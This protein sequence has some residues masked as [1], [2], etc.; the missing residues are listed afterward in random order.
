MKVILGDFWEGSFLLQYSNC[1]ALLAVY[2]PGLVLLLSQL[3]FTGKASIPGAKLSDH[4]EL[5]GFAR[6]HDLLCLGAI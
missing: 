3:D 2:F 1:G 6:S 4:S 5:Q